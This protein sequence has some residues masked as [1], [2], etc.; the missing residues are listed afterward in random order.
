MTQNALSS[1][2]MNCLNVDAQINLE[3][4]NYLL[5]AYSFPKEG[6]PCFPETRKKST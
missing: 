3:M 4:V 1:F 2:I 6:F 5:M